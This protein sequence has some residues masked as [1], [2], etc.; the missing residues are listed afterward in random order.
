MRGDILNITGNHRKSAEGLMPLVLDRIKKE[1]GLFII[2]IAGESGAGKSE[3]ASALADLLE[4]A[5]FPAFI[6]QQDDFFV[7]P[8]K[9]NA[10]MRVR[11]FG[12]VGI[13]EV[14]LGLIEDI[15]HSVR[16]SRARFMKPLV[17]FEEDR[18]EEETIDIGQT[19][20]MIVEGTYVS[21]L[22]DIDLRVFIDRDFNDT[23]P[24]RMKR[25]REMQDDFLEKILLKEHG[26]ISSHKQMADVIINKDFSV[27][28]PGS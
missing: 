25:S 22:K 19:R 4:S 2:S 8:P 7:Y 1:K 16:R 9:T 26:I 10:A 3:I 13:Q 6:L 20:V 27:L 24:D 12:H 21:S 11:D 14:R 18:I 17:V 23:R 5:G 15:I 28:I